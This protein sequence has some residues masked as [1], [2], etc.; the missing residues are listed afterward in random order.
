MFSYKVPTEDVTYLSPGLVNQYPKCFS[1]K[2]KYRIPLS[3]FK[4][5]FISDYLMI[6]TNSI[7]YNFMDFT[8]IK[9]YIYDTFCIKEL[10]NT[11]K[12]TISYYRRDDSY[13]PP[14]T[15]S[16]IGYRY[17]KE[18]PAG[19]LYFETRNDLVKF[20]LLME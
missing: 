8:V 7:F 9:D 2:E 5:Y 1:F 13:I 12:G 6:R 11:D 18:D 14:G 15:F 3:F 16:N 17:F 19:T 20:K 10:H 4:S